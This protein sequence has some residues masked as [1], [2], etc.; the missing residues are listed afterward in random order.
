MPTSAEHQHTQADLHGLVQ[1]I[2]HWGQELG[3]QQIGI[4]DTD[5][6]EAETHLLSWLARGRH[7]EMGYMARH[8]SRRS[9]PADLRPGTLRVI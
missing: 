7:G 9:R 3:F 6:D 2:K 5:L 8:G 4:T 1:R